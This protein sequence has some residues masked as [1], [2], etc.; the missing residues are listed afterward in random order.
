MPPQPL[1]PALV[2]LAEAVREACRRAALDGYE[3][4]AMSG[5]CAEGA[6]EAAVSAIGMVD[7]REVIRRTSTA[8]GPA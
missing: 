2:A 5:L 4:A 8:D 3:H 1:D 7:V 6:W